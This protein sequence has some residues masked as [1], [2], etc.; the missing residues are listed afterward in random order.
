MPRVGGARILTSV[1]RTFQEPT[2]VLLNIMSPC[3]VL[4]RP[5]GAI[6]TYPYKQSR[7]RLTTSPVG[8]LPNQLSTVFIDKN[9]SHSTQQVSNSPL[10][11]ISI[12]FVCRNLKRDTASEHAFFFPLHLCIEAMTSISIFAHLSAGTA[13]TLPLI[14]RLVCSLLLSSPRITNCTSS[15]MNAGSELM[16]L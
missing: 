7:P 9:W 11:L 16:D 6:S 4:M 5:E 15:Y 8:P 3:S 1:R 2:S 10:R 14:C 13:K 12:S